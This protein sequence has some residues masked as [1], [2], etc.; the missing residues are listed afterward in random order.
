MSYKSKRAKVQNVLCDDKDKKLPCVKG[1]KGQE[2]TVSYFV[3][4]LL[5]HQLM[6]IVLVIPFII[7]ADVNTFHKNFAFVNLVC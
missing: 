1:I 3:I 5:I 6:N 4:K 7:V 2:M